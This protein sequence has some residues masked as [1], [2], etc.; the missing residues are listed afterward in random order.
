MFIVCENDPTNPFKI[1]SKVNLIVFSI[2][3]KIEFKDSIKLNCSPFGVK[4]IVAFGV[5]ATVVVV[6]EIV[7]TV[8]VVGVFSIGISPFSK[9]SYENALIGVM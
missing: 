4:V 8:V 1:V 9:G 5:G 6:V 3:F 2:A 7:G